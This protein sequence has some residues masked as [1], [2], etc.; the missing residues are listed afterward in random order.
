[1]VRSTDHVAADTMR[2]VNFHYSQAMLMPPS[3]IPGFIYHQT[4]RTFRNGTTP[5]YGGAPG[6]REDYRCFDAN[7]RDFDLLGHRYSL[8]STVGTAGLNL[9]FAMLPARDR[10]EF[11]KLPQSERAF[12]R[13]W[14]DFADANT[15]FLRRTA[16]I[17]SLGPPTRGLIVT[18]NEH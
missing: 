15:R 11:E 5:C 9:A 12:V 17:A 14:V 18:E 8:L 16:P 7:T 13:D 1:M 2:H 4:E 3:R 10:D 6:A